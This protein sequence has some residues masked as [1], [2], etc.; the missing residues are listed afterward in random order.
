MAMAPAVT[1]YADIQHNEIDA[2]RAIFME[3]FKE[4]TE[5]VGAWNVSYQI[6]MPNV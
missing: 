1:D 5:K 4:Q 3:D 6:S 2:L